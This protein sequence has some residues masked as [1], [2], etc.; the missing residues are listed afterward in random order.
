MTHTEAEKLMR[1][2]TGGFA[3]ALYIL[4]NVVIVGVTDG[5]HGRKVLYA[6]GPRGGVTNIVSFDRERARVVGEWLL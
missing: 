2:K 5:A 4:G 6:V 3:Q 1:D